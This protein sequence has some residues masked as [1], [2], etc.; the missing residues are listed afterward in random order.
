MD[1]VE[2]QFSGSVR[3]RAKSARPVYRGPSP[4]VTFRYYS[5]LYFNH[6]VCR[7]DQKQ[8]EINPSRV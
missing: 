6:R 7:R 4:T 1:R 3:S 5:S 8:S 2:T